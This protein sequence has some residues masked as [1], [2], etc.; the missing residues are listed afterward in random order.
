MTK[1]ELTQERLR[2]ILD[3]DPETGIFSRK[4]EVS[5]KL[6]Q[7]R[8]KEVLQFDPHTGVF[9][10]ISKTGRKVS[11]GTEAGQTKL[12]GHGTY[13]YINIDG[14]RYLAQ[15]LAW[16]WCTGKWP[17][18]VRFR[19]ENSLNCAF[20]NLEDAG[21]LITSSKTE[22]GY[23]YIRID[24]SDHIA[25]R[26]AWLYVYGKWPGLLRYRNGDKTNLRIANLRD[27]SVESLQP[28]DQERSDRRKAYYREQ[29]DRVRDLEFQKKFGITLGQ[30]REMLATQNGVCAIC[31]NE[32]SIK[33]NGKTRWLAVDHCHNSNKVRGLLCGACNPMI[34]YAKD[35][36]EILEKAIGYLK[37]HQLDE[38]VAMYAMSE[39]NG[40]AA[41]E[42]IH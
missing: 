5:E 34:G 28:S 30:Y 19:D 35:R 8:L 7:D 29:R 39:M 23:L 24:G 40:P 14:E 27:S 42:G 12:V 33:R 38:P 31:G 10:W 3:Y 4:S 41:S 26:L 18:L 32:E 16:L 37:E 1:K 20:D 9:V 13:R 25:A 21:A 11:V 17:R 36:I 2:E 6:T 15:R 22:A